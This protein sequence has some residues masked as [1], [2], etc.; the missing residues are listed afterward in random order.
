MKFTHTLLL[1][2]IVSC[3][4]PSVQKMEINET[5]TNIDSIINQSR[6]NLILLDQASRESDSS[7]AK[8]VE[9]TVKQI[10]TLKEEVKQLKTENNALKIKVDDAD[11][12]GKPFELLP[13]SGGKDD[14]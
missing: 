14:R 2:L 13:V 9:K 10:T 5:D 3:G 7:I 11:D 6:E 4:T 8:K 12:A 1:L